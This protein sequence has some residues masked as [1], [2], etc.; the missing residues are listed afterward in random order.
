MGAPRAAVERYSLRRSTNALRI[1]AHAVYLASGVACMDINC[2]VTWH[3]C[4]SVFTGRWRLR[5]NAALLGLSDPVRLARAV[6][7]EPRSSVDP[8]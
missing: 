8:Q 6:R 5:R 2:C 7:Q 4:S 3:F 1:D